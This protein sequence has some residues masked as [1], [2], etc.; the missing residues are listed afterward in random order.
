MVVLMFLKW[1]NMSISMSQI[2]MFISPLVTDNTI[3]CSSRIGSAPYLA[4]YVILKQHVFNIFE[5]SW[6][7]SFRI[8][9]KYWKMFPLVLVMI[10]LSY[11]NLLREFTMH[12]VLIKIWRG[13]DGCMSWCENINIIIFGVKLHWRFPS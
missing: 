13:K 10:I 3:E 2:M 1:I 12:V 6:S 7:F 9:R 8:S 4:K 11:K 5:K